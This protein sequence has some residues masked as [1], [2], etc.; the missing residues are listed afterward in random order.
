MINSIETKS[1]GVAF[2]ISRVNFWLLLY[3]VILVY[4][5]NGAKYCRATFSFKSIMFA[6]K[7]LYFLI[8][9][10]IEIF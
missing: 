6:H 2:W 5:A 3:Y 4:A 10:H 7:E 9:N 8:A 1:A